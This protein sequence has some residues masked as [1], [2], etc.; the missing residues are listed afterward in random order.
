[1]MPDKAHFRLQP[2]VKLL[3]HTLAHLM[4]QLYN[5]IAGRIVFVNEYQRLLAMHGRAATGGALK[6]TL[7]DQPASG[8]FDA[9]IRLWIVGVLP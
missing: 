2:D 4:S 9:A 8:Q 7:I 3:T 5:I 1:M 6:L